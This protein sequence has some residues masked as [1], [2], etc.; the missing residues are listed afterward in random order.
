MTL[1]V[2]QP[3]WTPRP[4]FERLLA[5]GVVRAEVGAGLGRFRRLPASLVNG[6]GELQYLRELWRMV[7]GW[8]RDDL[9]GTAYNESMSPQTIGL[10]L[11]HLKGP[12]GN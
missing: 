8:P 7:K 4:G 9:G 12:P 5:C 11:R 2:R 1:A 3:E 10:M 6:H